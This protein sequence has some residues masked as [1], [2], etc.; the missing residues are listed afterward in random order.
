MFALILILLVA[1]FYFGI[2]MI[3]SAFAVPFDTWTFP[4]WINVIMGVLLL[5]LGVFN[6]FRAWNVAKKKSEKTKAAYNAELE[7]MREKKRSI[8]LEDDVDIEAETSIKTS[9]TGE[10]E[11]A[12]SVEKEAE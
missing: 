1:C 4:I 3:V 5:A 9:E 12:E 6:A 2:T 11:E 8:Y 10:K 7:K